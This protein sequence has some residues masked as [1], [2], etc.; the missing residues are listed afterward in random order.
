LSGWVMSSALGVPTVY[1]GI[2]QLPDLI[3]KNKPLGE[4]LKV[5]HYILNKT[6]L[7]A[8]AL[9]VLM[10]LKHHFVDRDQVLHSM[11]PFVRGHWRTP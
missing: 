2:W 5:A 3:A 10:A 7:V 11:L 6:L 9:H 4:A 8:V 1:L